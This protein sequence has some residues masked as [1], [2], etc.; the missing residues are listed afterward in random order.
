MVRA[1]WVKP[2]TLVQ[3]FEANEAV[4]AEACLQISC[5]MQTY[6]ILVTP[7]LSGTDTH[8]LVDG[9]NP[10]NRSENL[11]VTATIKNHSGSCQDGA[12][13]I[14]ENGDVFYTASDGKIVAKIDENKDGIGV[15]DRVY[16][17]TDEDKVIWGVK[18]GTFRWNHWGTV[19]KSS[20]RS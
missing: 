2:M 16:W 13:I 5:D 3:K 12:N 19:E 8:P 4:A 17:C 7:Y 18:Y 9:E 6:G 10:W 11:Y 15:G 20:N 14:F 1:T